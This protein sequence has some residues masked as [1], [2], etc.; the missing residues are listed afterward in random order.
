MA[1][2]LNLLHEEILEQRQ[3]QRDPLKI[4]MLVLA[5]C[6]AVLFLYYAWNA[7]R[8]IEIKARLSHVT[9]D[10]KKIEPEVTKAQKRSADLTNIINTTRVLDDYIDSRFFWGPLLDKLSRC[11]P[12]NAQLTSLEGQVTDEEK[13]GGISVTIDGV[14]AAREPRSAAEDMRQMLLEQLGKSYHDVKAE[15]KT[16]EDMETVANIGGTNVPMSH[17]VLLVT[18]NPNASAK[19]TPT[20]VPT[21]A[22]PRG[23]DESS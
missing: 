14:A 7:Y 4:G 5:S 6:G 15:F 9:A 8:T 11:V 19:P 17:Y 1:L 2:H 13:G 18:L 22:K 20:P 23:N 21:R 12:P 10:W 3:R 16:L